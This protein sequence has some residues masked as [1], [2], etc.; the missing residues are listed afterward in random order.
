MSTKQVHSPQG[1]R[2]E[3]STTLTVVEQELLR[4]LKLLTE[5]ERNGSVTF[6][7]W[8]SPEP[9]IV[10][11]ISRKAENDIDTE[12]CSRQGLAIVRRRSGGGTVWVG[13]GTLQYSFVLPFSLAPELASI[14]R[15]KIFCGRIVIE[16]LANQISSGLA[17]K[18][19]VDKS[20]DLRL[21]ERKCGGVALK[22]GRRAMLLHGTILADCELRNVITP[23]RHPQIEPDYRRGRS[24][25]DFL[26]TLGPIDHHALEHSVSSRFLL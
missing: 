12:Y 11:G 16:A 10:L 13:P 4:D 15:S 17:A 2:D 19:N 7:T 9:T 23:L 5:C 24:H 26:T 14:C 8:Q 1:Q 3:S 22:R 18:L 6:R 21:D 25:E 20:G